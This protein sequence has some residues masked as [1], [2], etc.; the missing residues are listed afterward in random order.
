MS[1]LEDRFMAKVFVLGPDDCWLWQGATNPGSEYGRMTVNRKT[2]YAHRVSYELFV[3]PIPALLQIDHL[4][5]NKRCVNPAHLEPVTPAENTRRT[6]RCRGDHC[7]QG[8][9]YDGNNLREH[10]GKRICRTCNIERSRAWRAARSSG[11]GE[12][13]NATQDVN[14]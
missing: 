4:C 5:E 12:A 7:P 1:D 10:Q 6:D 11:P 2:T 13:E 9:P 8:H 3:G 14:P